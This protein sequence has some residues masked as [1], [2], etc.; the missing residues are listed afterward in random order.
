MKKFPNV[1][2]TPQYAMFD[3]HFVKL[4]TQAAG[5]N[6]PDVYLVQTLYLVEYA[7]KGL[8][9]PLQDL[10]DAKKI[11]VSNYTKG[12]LSSS[13]YNG[14]VVG[15]T[16][17]DTAGGMA[18]NKSII[19][20]AGHPL[21][22]DQ[23]TYSEFA[24]YLKALSPKL[25]KDTYAFILNNNN[26]VVIENFTRNYGGY[27]L[28]TADGKQLGYT[29]D[30]LT[31]FINFYY[32][33]FK[34]GVSGNI[35][36]IYEDRGKN[37]GDS[38][39]GKG[40]MAVW[41]TNINQGK[42]FQA[43]TNEDIVMLRYPVADNATN[44]NIE[45]A[46][47]STLAISGQTKKVDEAA[48]FINFMVNDWEVQKIYDMDIGVPGSTVIQQNLIAGL[49]PANKVDVA[50]K[51]EIELMQNILQTIEPF[52]GRPSNT[53]AVMQDIFRKIEAVLAGSLTVQQ[54]VDAH[55]EAAKTLLQ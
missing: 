4:A 51:R 12:A 16:L 54:A 5:G 33:L 36:V 40:R 18:F 34:S 1:K 45:V 10:I 49:N 30:I 43:T 2:V 46:I 14:K 32:D 22:K 7:S 3:D 55:F 24:A 41:F 8:M 35:D 17:G 44:K 48:H 13:S 47:C 53:G 39:A 52:G 50:K 27:G 15:I 19:E 21:P 38:L 42:I 9:R 23:M 26:D 28:V 31:K 20:R 6:L 37:W 11:D 25:P 29:K